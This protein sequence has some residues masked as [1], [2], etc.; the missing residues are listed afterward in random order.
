[1]VELNLRYVPVERRS[2]HKSDLTLFLELKKEEPRR[3][4]GFRQGD[5]VMFVSK[6]GRRISFVF[7]EKVADGRLYLSSL[8]LWLTGGSWDPRMIVDYAES[9]GIILANRKKFEDFFAAEIRRK[10]RGEQFRPAA[11][12]G[13]RKAM[14]MVTE[15]AVS[16]IVRHAA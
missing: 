14:K 9:A 8:R 16:K 1:M 3:V 5:A 4:H 15:P 2:F 12:I 10:N 13:T 6:T 7:G 11:K